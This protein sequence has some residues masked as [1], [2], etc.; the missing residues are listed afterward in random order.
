MGR[1]VGAISLSQKDIAIEAPSQIIQ[2]T[3]KGAWIASKEI[4]LFE[5]VCLDAA[6]CP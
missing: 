4:D 5:Y 1:E 6:A 3:R 2:F